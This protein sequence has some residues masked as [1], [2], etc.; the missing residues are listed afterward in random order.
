MTEVKNLSLQQ[1]AKAKTLYGCKNLP[2]DIYEAL[3]APEYGHLWK[4]PDEEEEEKKRYQY[5]LFP[6]LFVY[7]LSGT[8]KSFCFS[9]FTLRVIPI[10]G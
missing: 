6:F 2:E 9:F 4:N 7:T 1:L 8:K 5:T 10:K 3:Q